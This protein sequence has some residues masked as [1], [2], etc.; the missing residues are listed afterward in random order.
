MNI[1][2]RNTHPS[3]FRGDVSGTGGRDAGD[4]GTGRRG[5]AY[6]VDGRRVAVGGRGRMVASHVPQEA[7]ALHR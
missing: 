2:G 6:A 7:E 5:V 1:R 4:A 3:G